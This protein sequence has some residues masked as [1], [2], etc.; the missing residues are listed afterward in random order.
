MARY[1]R[2]RGARGSYFP[3]ERTRY[4]RTYN[5]RN[6]QDNLSTHWKQKGEHFVTDYIMARAMQKVSNFQ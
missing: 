4:E 2:A 6:V 1:Y 3:V 5:V